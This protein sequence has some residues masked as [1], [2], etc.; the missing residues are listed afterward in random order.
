[1]AS[2]CRPTGGPAHRRR[3]G[4]R[5]AAPLNPAWS[6]FSSTTT[7]SLAPADPRGRTLSQLCLVLLDST[8]EPVCW[9]STCN[10]PAGPPLAAQS[11]LH[12]PPKFGAIMQ[13]ELHI[14]TNLMSI[15]SRAAPRRRWLV[16][17]A[18]VRRAPAAAPPTS[19]PSAAANE[20]EKKHNHATV[21]H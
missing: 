21:H 18:S 9:Y 15:W 11:Y 8:K 12:H 20:A 3:A 13:E 14:S 5:P 19:R 2:F 10:A 7:R 17:S 4:Q 1:M 6:S 16:A